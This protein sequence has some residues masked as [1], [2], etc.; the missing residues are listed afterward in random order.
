MRTPDDTTDDA[1]ADTTADSVPHRVPESIAETVRGATWRLLRSELRLVLSR[2]R[3]QAGLAVLAVVPVVIAIAVK[4]AGGG[5]SD[6]SGSTTD[7]FVGSVAGNGFFVAL[8]ALSVEIGLFLPLAVAALSGDAIAGE[9]NVGTLRGLLV[10]PVPRTRLLAVKYAA[11]VLGALLA[12]ALVAV[13]GLVAGAALFGLHPVTTL[14]GTTLGLGAALWRLLLVGLYVGAFLAALGALGLF[15]STLTEQPMGATIAVVLVSTLMW[16]LDSISQLHAIHPWL[17]VDKQLAFADLLR[18][19]VYTA[20]LRLGL[21]TDLAY[22]V[23]FVT[24]AWAR[25]GS[26]DVTS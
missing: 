26:R 20:D 15:V 23:V 25:F 14:S 8:A 3:N 16:I 13:V 19:P 21:L 7:S 1:T 18:D 10:V 9:A 4:V 11:V 6:G 17:L 5:A 12:V 24:A 22:G 2:R